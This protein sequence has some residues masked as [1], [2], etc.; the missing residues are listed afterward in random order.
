M[1]INAKYLFIFF[2]PKNVFE[3]IGPGPDLL[4]LYYVSYPAPEVVLELSWFLYKMLFLGT[5]KVPLGQHPI[6]VYGGEV[7]LQTQSGKLV[8]L[9]LST[10]DIR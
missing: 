10:H 6:L 7:S 3:P 2:S 9:T 5:T 4:H 1:F 8:K